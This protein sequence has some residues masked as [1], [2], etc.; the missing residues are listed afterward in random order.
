MPALSPRILQTLYPYAPLLLLGCIAAFYWPSFPALAKAWSTW[1]GGL[2]HGW[3]IIAVYV[4]LFI[5]NL[6]FSAEAYRWNWLNGAVLVALS[7]TWGLLQLIQIA[8]LAQLT[9]LAISLV[10]MACLIG[11]KRLL[12][13]FGLLTLPIYTLTH[14]GDLIPL[15]VELSSQSVGW[16]IKLTHI[17]AYIDGNSIFLPYGQM[18]IADGCS[19]SRYLIISLALAHLLACFSHYR[20]K[21]FLFT[22]FIAILLGLI[23]NWLRIF[24]LVLIGY[25]SQMQSTLIHD[26]E[27]FGW[28]LFAFIVG[29]PLYFAPHGKTPSATPRPQPASL[30]P[31]YLTLIGLS[32]GP[33]FLTF[34]NQPPKSSG[35]AYQLN[36]NLS[37]GAELFMDI[38]LANPGAE[39]TAENSQH[40][41]KWQLNQFERQ[42][43][44][45]KLV[46]F[47]G[48]GF[49][50]EVWLKT[51]HTLIQPQ[52]MPHKVSITHFRNKTSQHNLV[53]LQWYQLGEQPLATL[54]QAKLWQII[55]QLKGVTQFGVITLQ[56]ECNASCEAAEQELITAAQSYPLILTKPH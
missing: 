12:P 32:L 37:A 55:A 23:A 22:L 10:A 3:M 34:V 31:L 24:I 29:I 6:P 52:G 54:K 45:Q 56:A 48:R 14:W 38:A 2:S 50:P 18:V 27:M 20:P 4:Y 9:L 44:Q 8:A 51:Q 33:L 21:A 39:T 11:W 46:P 25:Y 26:H 7:L 49:N 30:T 35:Y 1:D 16:L 47:L 43:A 28:V 15:L 53:Q 36:T 19:G 41:V 40:S 13:Y 42:Q 17:P 5:R